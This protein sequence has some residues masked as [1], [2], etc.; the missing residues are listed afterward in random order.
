MRNDCQSEWLTVRTTTQCI[1]KPSNPI[2]PA[3][4]SLSLQ[5]PTIELSWRKDVP[6]LALQRR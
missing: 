5:G 6:I 4:L 1:I 2:C 3:L